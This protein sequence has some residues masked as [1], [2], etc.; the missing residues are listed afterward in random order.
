MIG[1]GSV[2]ELLTTVVDLLPEPKHIWGFYKYPHE[3]YLAYKAGDISY[4]VVKAYCAAWGNKQLTVVTPKELSAGIPLG[5][6]CEVM[7]PLLTSVT[8]IVV[9]REVDNIDW[10][11]TLP[12]R[13]TEVDVR[14]CTAVK[15]FSPLLAMNG[16]RKVNYMKDINRSFKKIKDQLKNKGVTVKEFL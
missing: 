7:L 9:G 14:L 2:G 5:D 1:G 3:W 16:L 10:C 8:I 6:Y 12:E 13:I 11:A 15:D 4:N